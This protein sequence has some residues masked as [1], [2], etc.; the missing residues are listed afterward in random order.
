MYVYI[1]DVWNMQDIIFTALAAV[2]A[3]L[4]IMASQSETTLEMGSDGFIS[5]PRSIVDLAPRSLYA[6]MVV[7]AYLR[8]LQYLRYFQSVGV[9]TIVIGHMMNDVAFF[10]IILLFVS[11]G[12][13]F[14]FMALSPNAASE[15]S[16]YLLFGN[17]P[18]WTP[19][20]GIFGS[21][22]KDFH[23][24]EVSSEGDPVS[25]VGPTLLWI[26]LFITTIILVN[27]LIAQ[28]SDTYAKVTEKGTLVWQYER[29]HL[30]DEFKDTKPPLPP[31]LNVLWYAFVTL[32]TWTY[33][34]YRRNVHDEVE[35]ASDGFKLVPDM[36]QLNTL[37]QREAEALRKCLQAREKKKEDTMEA[38]IERLQ[39]GMTKI[40]DQG[41]KNTELIK[42]LEDLIKKKNIS[43]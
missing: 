19:F 5:P 8:V 28:M 36:Q 15:I 40:D 29:A 43:M 7:L 33:K 3:S 10:S 26:Y 17:A 22:N 20:W 12:F 25:V 4:R 39:A 37:R 1:R 16:P 14:A 9:L 27:L 41:R 35:V 32:P 13:G 31:P 30:I 38:Q 6:F 42:G 11:F 24:D 23:T 18:M 21:Y 2:I 34:L